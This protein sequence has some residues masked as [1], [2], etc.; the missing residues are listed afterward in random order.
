[1][2]KLL[3]IFL[4]LSMASCTRFTEQRARFAGGDEVVAELGPHK[5]FRTELEGVTNLAVDN[6]DSARMADAYIRQWAT[7][8][9]FYEKARAREDA[10]LEALVDD[11]RRSL[12]VHRYE[13]KL[14]ERK[15]PQY[16]SDGNVRS[17]YEANK[18]LYLL[19][20]DIIKGVLMIVPQDAPHTEKVKKWLQSPEENIE[21]I[22]KYA[23]HYASGYQLFT[24][25]W[26]SGNRIL[27]RM[28]VTEANFSRRVKNNDYI[29]LRDSTAI[30]ML[31]ITDIHLVGEPMPLDYAEPQIRAAIL[32]KRQVDFIRNYRDELYEDALDRKLKIKKHE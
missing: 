29:E 6:E 26:V 25:E 15:M 10:E 8:I 12:Y 23:Y 21:H 30:Y 22:E 1:M 17:F 4:V 7:D 3:C 31:Q 11:Y 9:L 27:A 24:R 18:D 28:P 2:K 14:L 13:E 32:Q 16:V 5:M 20:E 19:H